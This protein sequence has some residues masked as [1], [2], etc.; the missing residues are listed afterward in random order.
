MRQMSGYGRFPD[1]ALEVLN[2]N[3]RWSVFRAAGG[4]CVQ[5]LPHVE[6]VFDRVPQTPSIFA[7]GRWRE[8]TIL[9]GHPDPV[10]RTAE[11]LRGLSNSKPDVQ[12]FAAVRQKSLPPQPLDHSFARL[13]EIANLGYN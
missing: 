1:A 10:G 5:H 11:Q 4:A 13:R 2:G 7:R 6:Y 9:F 8:S 12:T 3:H